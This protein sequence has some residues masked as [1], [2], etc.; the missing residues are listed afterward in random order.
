MQVV[1]EATDQFVLCRFRLASHSAHEAGAWGVASFGGPPCLVGRGWGQLRRV[2]AFPSPTPSF[3]IEQSMVWE[4][5]WAQLRGTCLRGRSEGV[6]RERGE[7]GSEG[8][9]APE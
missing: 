1:R 9:L 3:T 8:S 7:V 4:V 5:S 6:A 2:G